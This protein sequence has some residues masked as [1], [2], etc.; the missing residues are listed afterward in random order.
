MSF[1]NITGE[2]KYVTGEMTPPWIETTL[3]TMLSSYSLENIFNADEFGLFHHSLPNKTLHVKR[4]ECSGGKHSKVHL[5]GLAAGNAYGE[6][7]PMFVRRKSKN[8]VC[9]KGVKSLPCR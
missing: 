4:E 3:P 7:R 6:R 5:T 1:K 8:P 2:S 9:F